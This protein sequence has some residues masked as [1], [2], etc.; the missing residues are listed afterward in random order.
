MVAITGRGDANDA[1][2]ED[3]A[4]AAC[5]TAGALIGREGGGGL[6]RMGLAVWKDGM[7]DRAGGYEWEAGYGSCRVGCAMVRWMDS[8]GTDGGRFMTRLEHF[9]NECITI[10]NLA[11][12]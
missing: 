12:A 2:S 8:L 4:D 7:S 6:M 5:A 11:S 10:S 9:T 1:E 3:Q